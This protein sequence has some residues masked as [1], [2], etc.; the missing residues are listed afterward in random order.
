MGLTTR[1]V[2]DDLGPEKIVLVREPRARLEAV[3]VVDNVAC[4]PA[5]GGVRMV[6]ELPRPLTGT[7]DEPIQYVRE[8][9]R[10][11]APPTDR[12]RD[13]M[14]IDTMR[15]DAPVHVAA[16]GEDVELRIGEPGTSSCVT[17]LSVPQAEMVLHALG[18]AIAQVRE[19][20][21]REAEHRAHLAQVILDTEVDKH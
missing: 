14:R 13:M 3:V 2:G 12:R 20:Q 9:R 21:R 10:H 17:T 6:P 18:L 16:P 8:A 7:G 11:V 19:R 5:I 1:G 4:G 15:P